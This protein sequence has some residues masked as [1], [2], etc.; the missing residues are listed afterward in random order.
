MYDRERKLDF[1]YRRQSDLSTERQSLKLD[2]TT[3][4]YLCK[5]F[6]AKKSNKTDINTESE[7]AAVKQRN[8]STN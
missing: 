5:D 6:N 1:I 3:V 8:I 4:L 7:G 2:V